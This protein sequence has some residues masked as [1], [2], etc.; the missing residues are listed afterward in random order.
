MA[1]Q[2]RILLPLWLVAR[3][4]DLDLGD[5]QSSGTFKSQRAWLSG[6]A[7]G[8]KVLMVFTSY[9]SANEFVMQHFGNQSH[10]L[11]AE[12]GAEQVIGVLDDCDRAGIQKVRVNNRHNI[13]LAPFRRWVR[14]QLQTQWQLSTSPVFP[15]NLE[16][17]ERQIYSQNGEDGVI[18]AIFAAIGTTNRYFVE[19]GCEDGSECNAANLVQQGWRGLSMD[20]A[21]ESDD[22]TMPIHK[23]M[24]TAENIDAL[25]RKYQVPHEFDLLSIDIDG[26]DFWVWKEITHHPRVVVI[27]YNAHFLPPQRRTIRYDPD[28]QWQ[29]TSYFGASLGALAELGRL[30]GYTL[31]HCDRAGANAFFIANEL[32]PAGY[33]PR[34]IKSIFRRPNYFYLGFGFPIDTERTMI[35]PFET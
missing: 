24:V 29:G 1:D 32:L 23:E 7:H 30:K 35:D 20:S 3:A 31:V 33:A 2:L 25:L 34:S 19:F 13:P 5:S 12:L 18:E 14:E 8:K 6:D 10:Y 9:T 26:N 28:F 4:E 11:T 21:H 27:E 16:A 22:P 15:D 17:A